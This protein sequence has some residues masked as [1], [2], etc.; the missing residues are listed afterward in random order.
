[1]QALNQ[2]GPQFGNMGQPQQRPEEVPTSQPSEQRNPTANVMNMFNQMGGF[3]AFNGM[4]G[5]MNMTLGDM[6][7]EECN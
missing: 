6:L 5:I 2:M 3:S 7:R 1:M 4:G